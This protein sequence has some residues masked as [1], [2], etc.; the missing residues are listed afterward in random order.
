ME[1]NE[2]NSTASTRSSI[3]LK[4]GF[5]RIDPSNDSVSKDFQLALE[6]PLVRKA[7][8]SGDTLDSSDGYKN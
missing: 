4:T 5:N 3:L 8:G 7:F 1:A 2:G 6:E